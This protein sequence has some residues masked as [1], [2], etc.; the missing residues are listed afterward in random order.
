MLPCVTND[1]CGEYPPLLPKTIEYAQRCTHTNIYTKEPKSYDH[2]PNN[3]LLHLWFA[4]QLQSPWHGY[5][6]SLV[7][8]R[9]RIASDVQSAV[10]RIRDIPRWWILSADVLGI[11]NVSGLR[12]GELGGHNNN[13]NSGC[14]TERCPATRFHLRKQISKGATGPR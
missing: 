10:T 11:P 6:K 7:N 5:Y 3:A 2:L 14:S 4:K 13:W 12:S 8:G 9:R 1:A